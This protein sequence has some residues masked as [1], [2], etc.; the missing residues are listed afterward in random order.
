M[1]DDR[2]F[3]DDLVLQI[4]HLEERVRTLEGANR[5]QSGSINDG[6]STAPIVVLGS[7]APYGIGSGILSFAADRSHVMLNVND[8]EGFGTPWLGS[9]WNDPVAGT[10]VTSGAFLGVYLSISEVFWS[11]SILFRVGCQ[12]DAAT[13]GEVRV[14]VSGVG[15]LGSVKTIP[16]NA[17]NYFE[18]R[19]LHGLAIGSG[20]YFVTVEARRASGAGNFKV[21]VPGP[22]TI[23]ANISAVAGGWV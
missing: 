20:P 12:T 17:N 2:L 11:N 10:V 21:L 7:L 16:I 13:T 3:P 19:M 6:T 18:Y 9:P 22:L 15:Q 5:L 14:T 1:A 23:G 8:I 4:K